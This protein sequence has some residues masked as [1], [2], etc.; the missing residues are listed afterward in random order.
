MAKFPYDVIHLYYPRRKDNKQ[1]AV[2]SF[3][4]SLGRHQ[5]EIVTDIMADFLGEENLKDYTDV[6]KK[7]IIRILKE[8]LGQNGMDNKKPIREPGITKKDI[9]SIREAHKE[10]ASYGMQK[11]DIDESR[12]TV[13]SY[14]KE[15]SSPAPVTIK[16]TSPAPAPAREREEIQEK[17]TEIPEEID[18]LDDD[19]DVPD[20]N[21]EISEFV[22]SMF[23]DGQG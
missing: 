7:E 10:S 18:L 9:E 15:K 4:K 12:E 13:P 6:S 19:D 16:E 20:Y 22:A 2:Y 23:D 8:R 3:I 17:I 1:Q 21:T 14:K 11:A 5:T